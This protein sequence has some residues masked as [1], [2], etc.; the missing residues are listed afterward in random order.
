MKSTNEQRT[1]ITQLKRSLTLCQKTGVRLFGMDDTIYATTSHDDSKDFHENYQE[2][3]GG[4]ED[5]MEV[6]V[7]GGVYLG[8]G[9]W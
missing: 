2:A 8:S 6:I 3:S 1:A 9:G 7:I 4:D 5:G